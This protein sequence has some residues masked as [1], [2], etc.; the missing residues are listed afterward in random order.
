M[1]TIFSGIIAL[2]IPLFLFAQIAKEAQDIEQV[3]KKMNKVEKENARLKQQ[4]NGVQRSLVKMS[5]AEN[6]DHLDFLK[7]DSIAKAAQDTARS[8]SGKLQKI[9]E[10]MSGIEHSL[11]LRSI[12]ILILMILLILAVA[13]L[14]WTHHRKH[15]K[16]YDELLEKMK[17]QRYER[18]QPVAERRAILERSENELTNIKKETG[19]RYAAVSDNI[20]HVDN[21]LQV[22]LNER[23]HDLELQT[24]DELSKVRKE[25]EEGAKDFLKKLENVQALMNSVTSRINEMGQKMTDLGKK[26]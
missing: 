4:L 17:A 6:K 21:N 22:L 24:K 10:D 3:N 25:N 16:D 26:V 5:E 23:T 11:N 7:H 1:K 15:N 19:D 9:N 18:E 20:A 2:I 8:Y 14:L 13:L 12:G